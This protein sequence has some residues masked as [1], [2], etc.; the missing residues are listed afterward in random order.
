MEVHHHPHHK[1]ERK[2]HHYFWEFFMLFIAVS[3]GFFLEN[4]REKIV[5]RHREKEYIESM[6]KD[7]KSDTT[8]INKF[9]LDQQWSVDSYDSVIILLGKTARSQSE[10]QRLYY[11]IRMAMRTSWPNEANQTAYDQMKF[12]GNLRLLHSQETIDHI[13]K[14]YF[15]IKEIEYITSL[16]TLRQQAVTEYEAKIVDG[17]VLHSMIN[18]ADFSFRMPEGNPVLFT[19]DRGIINEFTVR[20]HYLRSIMIYSI[21]FAKE[22]KKEAIT[23]LEFLEHEYHLH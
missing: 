23:L 18:E 21:N 12:S 11:L 3:A 7:L 14:Y 1:S 17:Q 20:I 22:Q 10:Q 13:S 2:W 4:Q 5:E 16:L 15:K 6:V 8:W 19:N 9:L